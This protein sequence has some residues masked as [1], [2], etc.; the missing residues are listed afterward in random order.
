[1][2][3]KIYTRYKKILWFFS[4]IQED[5]DT[6][7]MS[8][9]HVTV[10]QPAAHTAATSSPG[11][12]ALSDSLQCRSVTPNSELAAAAKPE[13]RSPDYSAKGFCSAVDTG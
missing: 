10:T 11:H 3:I 1:M 5:G 4:G 13:S 6:V 9:G 2:V 12:V 8:S 7:L